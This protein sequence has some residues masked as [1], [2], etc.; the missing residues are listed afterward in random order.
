MI[1]NEM[2]NVIEDIDLSGFTAA[3]GGCITLAIDDMERYYCVFYNKAAFAGLKPDKDTTTVT[4]VLKNNT[5]GPISTLMLSP[6]GKK[7]WGMNLLP[8]TLPAGATVKLP[9]T[10]N[11]ANMVWD[12]KGMVTDQDSHF[13]DI[14]LD[15]SKLRLDKECDIEFKL[16][17]NSAITAKASNFAVKT[18]H[19]K[20]SGNVIMF[21]D[22]D[23]DGILSNE[24]VEEQIEEAKPDNKTGI[25]ASFSDNIKTIGQLVFSGQKLTKVTL[26]PTVKTIE[27]EAF[28]NQLLLTE[29][30]FSEGLV[31]IGKL[32]FFST[33][34]KTISLPKSL[35][36]LG[37]GAF[38]NS[39]KLAEINLQEGLTSIGEGA[40]QNSEITGITLP[41]S[42]TTMEDTVFK[43][44]KKLTSISIPKG[45]RKLSRSTFFECSSTAM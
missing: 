1:N 5:K 32:G 6:S 41:E 31:S 14:K 15:F 45:I 11:K 30:S 7:A 19:P 28:E 13:E 43:K 23:N 25:E 8:R 42:L 33:A 2:A 10:I 16:D 26:P 39:D 4:F 29:A 40:F 44:C 27:S 24:E 3:K 35:Q 38:A 17:I 36:T 34:L 12:V 21:F 22:T 37:E 18:P 9:I 20:Q